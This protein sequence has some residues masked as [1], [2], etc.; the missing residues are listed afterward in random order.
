VAKNSPASVRMPAVKVEG[1][2]APSSDAKAE[3]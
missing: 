1:L 2:P 3:F